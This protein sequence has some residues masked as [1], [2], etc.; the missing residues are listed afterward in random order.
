M[1]KKTFFYSALFI[2]SASAFADSTPYI[3]GQLGLVVLTDVA[4][5]FSSATSG[6]NGKI[7]VGTLWGDDQFKYGIEANAMYFPHADA[8]DVFDLTNVTYKGASLSML[9]V[10]RYVFNC[11][12]LVEGKAGAAYLYE[13]N[14]NTVTI[15]NVKMPI[16]DASGSKIA[17]EVA[18]GVGYQ[19]NSHW[20]LDLV[21]DSIFAG[22]AYTNSSN[23]VQQ[24][25]TL[26]LGLSYHFA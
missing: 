10:A 17:P 2:A 24:T 13:K 3:G 12:F 11:G 5:P 1:L 19:F 20:D 25:N 26:N 14:K 23:P 21:A 9:G 16:S 15:D 18:L 4:T 7:L 6:G 8:G 22:N